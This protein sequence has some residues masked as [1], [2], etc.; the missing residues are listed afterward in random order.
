MTQTSLKKTKS[1]YQT[2]I[3]KPLWI[4]AFFR[5]IN[6]THKKSVHAQNMYAF[7]SAHNTLEIIGSTHKI[8]TT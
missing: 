3:T 6:S 7:Q 4:E 8:V 2:I 5:S 1:P